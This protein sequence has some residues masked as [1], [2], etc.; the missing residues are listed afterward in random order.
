MPMVTLEEAKPICRVDRQLRP[1][2]SVVIT[3]DAKAVARLVPEVPPTRKQR[4]PG[5]C[6]ACSRLLPT[7]MS[8][9]ATSRSTWMRHLLDTHT[10]LWFVLND[11]S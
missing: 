10:F 11:P 9:F 7:T 1:G 4:Q 8:T 3:R 5:N 6:K 2:E